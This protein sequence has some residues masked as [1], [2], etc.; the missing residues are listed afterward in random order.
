MTTEVHDVDRVESEEPARTE[1]APPAEREGDPLE[2]L[3]H[4]S[5]DAIVMVRDGYITGFNPAAARLLG[6]HEEDVGRVELESVIRL[7]PLEDPEAE[8][9]LYALRTPS[10]TREVD[11]QVVEL[12][13]ASKIITLRDLTRQR[14]LDRAKASFI[15]MVSHELRTPL[16]SIL[17]FSDVLLSGAAGPTSP[18]HAEFLGHIHASASHLVQIVNDILDLSRIDGGRFTLEKGPLTPGI[19][20]QQVVDGL[21]GLA[22]EAQVTL[23]AEVPDALPLVRADGRRVQQVLINLVGNAIRC[24]PPGGSVRIAVSTEADRIVYAVTD[25]GAGIPAEEHER[26]WER[27]YQRAT[28]PHL[29]TKGSGLGLTIARSLVEAHGGE[30]WLWSAPGEGSTFSFSLPL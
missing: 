27:F 15:S 19:P 21:G 22:R 30:I 20:V 14:E 4:Q 6:V 12:G 8:R 18:I 24:T 17:G 26:I 16:N 7:A 29:A 1:P 3:F 11:T 10:G 5:V 9:Q 28:T 25:T 23:M 13:G 2:A